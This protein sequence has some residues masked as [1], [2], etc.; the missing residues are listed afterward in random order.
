MKDITSIESL[1]RLSLFDVENPC[2]YYKFVYEP[3]MELLNVIDIDNYNSVEYTVGNYVIRMSW[4][5]WIKMFNVKIFQ[6][7]ELLRT[8]E[9]GV[10][11]DT[12]MVYNPEFNG[13]YFK[14]ILFFDL[15]NNKR[16]LYIFRSYDVMEGY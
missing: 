8:L 15:K 7:D 3:Q 12:G 11:S 2:K 13:S 14:I 16:P 1:K 10:S 9:Y 5:M 4:N 6:N